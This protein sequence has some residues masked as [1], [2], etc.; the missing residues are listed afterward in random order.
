M[1]AHLY[2]TGVLRR[3]APKKNLKRLVNPTPLG[4]ANALAKLLPGR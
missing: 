3:Q 2:D 4:V 1:R